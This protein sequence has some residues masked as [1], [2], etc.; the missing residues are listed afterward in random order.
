[1]SITVWHNVKTFPFIFRILLARFQTEVA[2]CCI[3]DRDLWSR[4]GSSRVLEFA[5]ETSHSDGN[6]NETGSFR[7]H[8]E[9]QVVQ[10]WM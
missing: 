6:W 4:Y 2:A 3:T 9:P 10:P 5:Q 1:M 8:R 7:V